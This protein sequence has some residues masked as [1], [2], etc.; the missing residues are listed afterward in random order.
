[1]WKI[2]VT[3][4]LAIAS[5]ATVLL[6]SAVFMYG[7][8]WQNEV[9]AIKDKAR[10][11]MLSEAPRTRPNYFEDLALNA[12][13]VYVYDVNTGRVLYQKNATV[14]LPLASI[15]KAMTAIV[16]EESAQSGGGRAITI[17]QQALQTEGESGLLEG[18]TWDLSKLLSFMLI[19]SSNDGAAAVAQAYPSFIERMNEK[20]AELRLDSLA[21]SNPTGLDSEITNDTGGY[22][23]AEDVAMLFKYALHEHPGLLEPTRYAVQEYASDTLIHQAK[24]TN[25]V[26][27]G[28]PNGIASKTGYTL[29][30]GGNLAIAF[31]RG[32]NEP[33]ILVV[34]GSS[35]DGR[36]EDIESLASTTLKT[37]N[38]TQ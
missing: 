21:F 15:T 25:P 36:F 28:I 12:Q 16:A 26:L 13:A 11:E 6:M 14:P 4:K 37:Y 32:L 29:K 1:M 33:V 23:S 31:D 17:D 7:S 38:Q 27:S 2:K 24:N 18:E 34:L 8:F 20:A 10:E 22:G 3:N 30:A 19:S 5:L 9:Q 35:Y